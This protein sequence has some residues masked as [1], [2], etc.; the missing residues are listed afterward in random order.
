MGEGALSHQVSNS[1]GP[2]TMILMIH[3]LKTS[4]V[5]NSSGHILQH[6]SIPGTRNGAM[7]QL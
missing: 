5:G 7:E 2:V 6:P 3:R 1:C 4:A